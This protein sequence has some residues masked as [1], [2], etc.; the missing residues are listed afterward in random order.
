MTKKS[1]VA[2]P[3][4]KWHI[5]MAIQLQV[6]IMYAHNSIV[7]ATTQLANAIIHKLSRSKV[8]KTK[9]IER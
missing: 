5:D 8:L 9:Q 2:M 7:Y 1:E 6:L 3:F 4:S